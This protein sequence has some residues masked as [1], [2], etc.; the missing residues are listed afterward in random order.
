MIPTMSAGSP[1]LTGRR[2]RSIVALMLVGLVIAQL[3]AQLHVLGHLRANSDPSGLTQ[4][5]AQLCAE[6]A[7]CVPLL[8]VAGGPPPLLAIIPHCPED[9][10]RIIAA[11]P[12]GLEPGQA[13]RARAPPA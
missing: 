11:T 7:S 6:C 3:A 12:A 8:M 9:A 13:F 5:H 10:S 1:S 2:S 4:R